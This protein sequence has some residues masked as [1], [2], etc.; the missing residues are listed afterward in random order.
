LRGLLEGGLLEALAPFHDLIE[1]TWKEGIETQI[2]E[3]AIERL[4]VGA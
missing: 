2:T 4:Q 3:Q 1:R